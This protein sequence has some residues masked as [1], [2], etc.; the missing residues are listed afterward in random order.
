MEKLEN[1]FNQ[2]KSTEEPKNIEQKEDNLSSS[3]VEKPSESFNQSLKEKIE[4]TKDNIS[5]EKILRLEEIRKEIENIRDRCGMPIDKEIKETVIIFNALGLSTSSS[6]GGHIDRGY[7]VPWIEISAPNEPEER[8]ISQNKSFEKVAK[9][10]NLTFEE[11]QKGTNMDA[12]WEAMRECSQNEET[13]EYKNWK[14]ENKNLFK[15]AQS[16]L[17]E[18][19]K[20]RKVNPEMKLKITEIEGHFRIHNGGRDYK[21]IV[22]KEDL[23]EKE[24]KIRLE[25]LKKYRSEMQ[26]FTEFLK[27]KYFNLPK[28]KF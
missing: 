16:F 21:P 3:N 17:K 7:L 14:K 25:K 13:E 8:F 28:E 9:K 27:R 19:Y 18:F 1:N 15:K 26:E 22:K 5:Q 4:L 10:Y 24:I 23:S 6:C 11:V 12:Y 2:I 20:K